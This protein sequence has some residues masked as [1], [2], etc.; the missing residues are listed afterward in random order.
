MWHSGQLAEGSGG[1]L[2]RLLPPAA[3][4][5]APRL[6]APTCTCRRGSQV[7]HE[8]ALTCM[9]CKTHKEQL[10]RGPAKQRVDTRQLKEQRRSGLRN[11]GPVSGRE[12]S[13]SESVGPDDDVGQKQSDVG[14]SIGVD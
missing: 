13:D 7:L 3:A 11:R 14:L 5:L 10:A 8:D 12:Q 2:L 1:Q 9:R 4:L 6:A